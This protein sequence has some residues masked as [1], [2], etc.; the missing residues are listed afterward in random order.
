MQLS[1]LM[2]HGVNEITQASNW[3]QE[4]SNPGPIEYKFDVLNHYDTE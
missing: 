4:D 3:Q 2:Q 1:E